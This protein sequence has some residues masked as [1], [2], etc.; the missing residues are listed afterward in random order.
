MPENQVSHKLGKFSG[1][2]PR[3]QGGNA[4][5]ISFLTL[6]RTRDSN[7][8]YNRFRSFFF[9][10]ICKSANKHK[11]A[12]QW[13]G[14]SKNHQ[15]PK[16]TP[17]APEEEVLPENNPFRVSSCLLIS[18]LMKRELRKHGNRINYRR[19][20]SETASQQG[21]Q[22]K[23]QIGNGGVRSARIL[24]KKKKYKKSNKG[25]LFGS[26]YTRVLFVKRSHGIGFC[27]G[28]SL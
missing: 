13:N 12:L 28:F 21:R 18:I 22:W 7:W 9:F 26:K 19:Q 27:S 2:P 24:Q 6:R 23:A 15:S 16:S 3:C 8:I 25:G 1:G 17:K 10:Q 14:K 20:G 5:A 11:V 4:F